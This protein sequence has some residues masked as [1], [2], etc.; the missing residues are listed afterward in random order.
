MLDLTTLTADSVLDIASF[1]QA[2]DLIR[3]EQTSSHFLSLEKE[4][5]WK[6]LCQQRWEPWPRYKLIPERLEELKSSSPY[7]SWKK[8]FLRV[9]QEATSME[10]KKCDLQ[11]LNWFLSFSQ[12]GV[13]GETRSDFQQVRFQESTLLVPGYPPLPYEIVNQAPP[14]I[15]VTSLHNS[16]IG[17]QPFSKKQWLKIAN[18]P[19]HAIAKRLA[20]AEWIIANRNVTM[21]S[22]KRGK[23]PSSSKSLVNFN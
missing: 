22:C 12:S 19:P 6:N 11:N 16:Q 1:L 17:D 15:V 4:Q 20:N 13:R 23:N 3:L 18:F 7:C 14:E 8:H 21:V 5:L 10:I 2:K 9:E